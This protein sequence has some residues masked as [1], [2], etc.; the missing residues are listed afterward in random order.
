MMSALFSAVSGLKSE[1][2]A[3]D[4]ISNNIANVNTTGYK[5]SRVSFS[6][7]LSQTLSGASS[8]TSTRG[9][10]NAKQVGLGTSIAST[11]LNMTVGSTTS[12]GVD[13]D[14]AISGSGFLVVTGGSEGKYQY[15]R[16]GDLT[17][18][19]DGNLTVNG[20]KVCGWEQYT[21]DADGD[22]VYSSSSDVEPINVYSDAYNGNKQ[23]MAAKATTAFDVTGAVKSSADVASTATGLKTIG[24]TVSTWDN[25]TE[26]KVYDSDG[27]A[28]SVTVNMKKC[29]SD[30]GVTSWYWEASS[31]DGVSITPSSGY[32]AIDDSTK[33]VVSSATVTTPTITGNTTN[34]TASDIAVGTLGD[35]TNTVSVA[36]TT[37]GGTTTYTLTLT[38]SS[39]NTYTGKSQSDG[40]YVFQDSSGNTLLT[41]S[42]ETLTDSTTLTFTTA[43]TTYTFDNTP[44][45]TLS[46]TDVGINAFNID[47]DM[48]AVKTTA[49]GTLSSSADGYTSGNNPSYSI[50]SDGTILATYSNSHSQAVGK[51]ALANFANSEGLEK[52]G[53]NLY[54]ST[55]SSG[56]ATICTAGES[57]TSSLASGELEMSNVDL[58]E[59]FTDMMISQRA[60][61]ANTKVIST[62]DTM[63]QS[64]INMIG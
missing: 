48:S 38:D 28:Y 13:T 9:S 17:I 24:G 20:Y 21:T 31:T 6:D 52:I 15:T 45:L 50:E 44:T 10:T 64:L 55:A 12:T 19:D 62:A 59:Q 36:S 32:I 16:E 56:N 35:G 2:T 53:S 42:K 39:G 40:S 34:F 23:I 3:L 27:N 26:Q 46:P 7:L 30:D 37:T 8:G 54:T 51:I 33:K 29:Y 43:E 4:V 1:Q 60:Y 47:L 49:S 11:T 57:G 58:A 5:A 25:S 14:V 18:D 22:Y 63:L 41:L 61:Q